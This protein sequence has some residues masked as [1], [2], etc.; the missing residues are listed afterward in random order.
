MNE[1]DQ[2]QMIQELLEKLAADGTVMKGLS[3]DDLRDA[4]SHPEASTFLAEWM[5]HEAASVKPGEP[6]PD[7]TLPYLDGYGQTGAT[8]TL[9]SHFGRR[10][11]ALI[12]GSYT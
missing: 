6:A 11:V 4:M 7:F 1:N 2:K 10:P 8:M 3:L 5:P 9:A 12:F